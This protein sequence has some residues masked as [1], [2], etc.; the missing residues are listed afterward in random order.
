MR[1]AWRGEPDYP[2]SFD[3]LGSSAPKQVIWR[4]PPWAPPPDAIAVVGSRRVSEAGRGWAFEVGRA[5][6][7]AGLAVVSG[8][9]LGVDGEAH[10]GA[11]AAHGRTCVVLPTPVDAP[12]PTRHRGLF[13]DVVDS[14]GTLLSEYTHRLG[15]HTFS[16]RNRLIAALSKGTVVVE[17]RGR[18]GTRHTVEAA[19]R[20]GRPVVVKS[21]APHDARGE[22]ARAFVA[23][24]AIAVKTPEEAVRVLASGAEAAAASTT[25]PGAR[26]PVLAALTEAMT[27]DDLALRVASTPRALSRVLVELEL[28]GAVTREGG[29]WRKSG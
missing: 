13:E 10:R 2:Q 12:S 15:R 27:L 11:L 14:G 9:A 24:G 22:G 23:L 26:H 6:A 17:A 21:W 16:E 4:G 29:R 5:V 20:L 28:D 8:G 7:Q 19:L 18:S 1:S 25:V 3:A